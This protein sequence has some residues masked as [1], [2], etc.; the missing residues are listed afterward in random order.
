MFKTVSEIKE[1]SSFDEVKALSDSQIQ[2]LI[3]RADSWIRRATNNP[4]LADTTDT[5]VQ[6]DLGIAT[7]LLVEYLW[8]W[9][10]AET[11]ESIMS[12]DDSIQIG[13]FSYHVKPKSGNYETGIKELDDI[14]TAYKFKLNAGNIFRVSGP[15]RM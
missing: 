12:Q 13:S 10:Q 8:Y 2:S 11:K 14:L 1:L 3:D 5:A 9:D 6:Q 4:T 15:S 7:W